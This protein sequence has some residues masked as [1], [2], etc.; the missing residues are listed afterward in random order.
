[1]AP[2]V[3]VQK[4]APKPA[5]AKP[6]AKPA[7]RRRDSRR[8]EIEAAWIAEAR[9]VLDLDAP[10]PPLR[11][12]WL[13]DQGDGEPDSRILAE[14]GRWALQLG[15]VHCRRAAG[16]AARRHDETRNR[17]DSRR[18]IER[19]LRELRLFMTARQRQLKRR[20]RDSLALQLA[21]VVDRYRALHPERSPEEIRASV[22]DLLA[23]LTEGRR[24]I[25]A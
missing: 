5:A 9:R 2:V 10:E 1:V 13:L 4:Q 7:V 8:A 23:G 6:A 15:A 12:L 19:G 11:H 22:R 25:A 14:L 21:V 18:T 20:R 24:S 17:K 3:S 16:V